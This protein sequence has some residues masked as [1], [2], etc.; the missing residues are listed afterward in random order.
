MSSEPSPELTVTDRTRVRR[1]RDRGDH[2]RAVIHAIVDEGLICHVGFT[3]DATPI[4]LPMAYGRV[5]DH[6]YLH[7]AP[8][9][10]MLATIGDGVEACVTVTLVDALVLARS[11]FHHSMNYRSAVLFATAR[12][13]VD[14]DEKYRALVAIVD[15]MV[16]GRSADARLPTAKE[17]RG[18]A[19]VRFPIEEGSAKIRTGGPVDDE[20]DL[21]LGIW[22][23]QIPLA[24]VAGA[25]VADALLPEGI[26]VPA[27]AGH[28]PD[29]SRPGV[30]ADS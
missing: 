25:P 3:V 2:R 11:A 16:P 14:D 29:R 23:G 5:G 27:Y 20:E 30:A 24:L 21:D 13:V 22:A 9:N 1:K 7:G 6:L 15:H 12:T 26:A 17:L 18:T 28:Y 4:V 19:V 8:A 10:A